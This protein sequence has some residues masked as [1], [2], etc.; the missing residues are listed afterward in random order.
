MNR[1]TSQTE[2]V[3]DTKSITTS[4]GYDA[5]GNRT[6]YTDGRGNTTIYTVNTLGLA[7]SVIEPPRPATRHRRP[8]PGPPRTTPPASR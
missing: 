1:L 6:R 2:P 4:F 5:L 7:E 8:A 3:S